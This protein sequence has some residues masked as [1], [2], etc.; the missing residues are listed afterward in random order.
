MKRNEKNPVLTR[1]DIPDIYPNM[2]NATSVFNPGAIKFRDKYILILR[3]QNRGRETFLMKA[4]SHNGIDFTPDTK[5]IEFKGIE[6]VSEKIY[7][8]YDA[9]VTYIDGRYFLIFAMDMETRCSLGLAV[10]D[11]FEEYEFLG[12]TS[13]EDT[14]NGVIFPEKFNGKYL[15]LERPNKVQL[16]GGPTSGNTIILSESEDLLNW[17]MVAPVMSGRFHYWDELIGSGP[18]PVKTREGWLHVY[19]GVATHFGSAN[20]YQGGVSLLDLNN[21]AKVIARGKYNILEPRELYELTGQVPNVCFPSGMIVEEFDADGFAKP[22]SRVYIYYGA[23]D[24]S[25]G[26]L[27]TTVQELINEAK[28]V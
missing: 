16:T 1:E 24:T 12:V 5:L 7:H 28:A 3:V 23:A 17:N 15:R 25:I 26:L 11:D 14:R 19:H 9:R 27:E 6:K 8:C 10:T 2:I 21:P 13:T 18:T 22:E 4:V 20:I